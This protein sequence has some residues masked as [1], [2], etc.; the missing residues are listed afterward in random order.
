VLLWGCGAAEAQPKTTVDHDRPIPADEPRAD[1]TLQ[2]DLPPSQ[3]C[4]EQFDLTLYQDR[5]IELIEWD[6]HGDAC[7]DRAVKIRYLSSK[8][9]KP[10]LLELVRKHASVKP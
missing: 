3:A 5:R 1:V 4:E 9:D 10:Q 2:L 8:I 7:T 6:E